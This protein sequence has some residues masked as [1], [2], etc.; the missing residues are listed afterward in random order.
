M[1][2]FTIL[3]DPNQQFTP[4]QISVLKVGNIFPLKQANSKIR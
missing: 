1:D 3:L 4:F 2:N